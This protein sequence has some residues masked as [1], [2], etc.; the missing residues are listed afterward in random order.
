MLNVTAPFGRHTK[1]NWGPLIPNKLGWM[2]MESPSIIVFGVLFYI[3]ETEKNLAH[4]L[5]FS[6]WMLH[7]VNRTI[8]YPL[9][10]RT[11]GKK[12][13]ITIMVFAI[14][15]QLTNGSLN[16]YY[17]G[18]FADHLSNEWLSDPRFII[19]AIL[20]FVGWLINIRADEILLGLRKPGE[21]GYKIPNGFLYEKIS[22]PNFFG[23]ML[24]WTGW[25]I[26]MW[27]F[28][29]FSFALWTVANLLPRALAHHK[30]YRET[31]EHYPSHRKAVIPYLL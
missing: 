7:Y 20:F 14:F 25:A 3:G 6:F 4:Y 31:F 23:E 5:L 12:M 16:G 18:N 19:G 10:T 8:V 27:S 22:C 2:I 17:L 1:K 13:P 15:F 9:R 11:T 21:S 24:E 28:P 29:A 30:W 26:A